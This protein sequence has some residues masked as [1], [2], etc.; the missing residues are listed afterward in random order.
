MID[1]DCSVPSSLTNS[2]AYV[3]LFIGVIWRMIV[4]QY[5]YSSHARVTKQI[6]T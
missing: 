5:L 6:I 4:K 1:N 2:Y 3:T